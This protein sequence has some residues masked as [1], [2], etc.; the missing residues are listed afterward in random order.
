MISRKVVES[1]GP[2]DESLAF[3]ED[4]EYWI[5][6]AATF[7]VGCVP[8]FDVYLLSRRGSRGKQPQALLKH[9]LQVV[10]MSLTRFVPRRPWFRARVRAQ[11]YYVASH[12]FSVLGLRREARRAILAAIARYPIEPN[13]YKRLARLLGPPPTRPEPVGLGS[14]SRRT[15]GRH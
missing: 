13:Y 12:D 8:H 2:F 9:S 4:W 14:A 15:A 10:G 6:V 11:V 5:R 1:V 7:P 3:G